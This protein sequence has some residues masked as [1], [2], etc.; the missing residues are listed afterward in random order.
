M[1]LFGGSSTTEF[2]FQKPGSPRA[3]T[4]TLR[5]GTG[6][7]GCFTRT[8][9]FLGGRETPHVTTRSNAGVGSGQR[10]PAPLEAWEVVH[11]SLPRLL[12]AGRVRQAVDALGERTAGGSDAWYGLEQ[13]HLTR[14]A[15]VLSALAHAYMFGK[16]QDKGKGEEKIG[17]YQLPRH[18]LYAWDRVP[19]D[20]VLNNAVGN[21][22]FSLRSIYFGLPEERL[23]SGLQ[24]TIESV[25]APALSDMALAKS[26]VLADQPDLVTHCLESL[27]ARI[28]E[29]AHVFDAMTPRDTTHFDPVIWIKTYPAMG[30]P[31]TPGELGNSGVD[32]PIFHAL[33]AFIG[34]QNVKGD[35]KG[36][37]SDRRATL[38]ANIRA[39]LDALGDRTGGVRDY[40]AAAHDR[41]RSLPSEQQSQ[42]QRL[43]AAW[44]GLLQM[45]V[46]FLERH[47][48]KA[49][50]VTGVSLGTGR[51][52]TSSGVK[53]SDQTKS[54]AA[55]QPKMRPETMLSMQMKMGMASRL[56]GRPLW[57][58]ARVQSQ[59]K[60]QGSVVVTV[61]LDVNL[62]LEPGDRVQIWPPMKRK[63][64]R[65]TCSHTR[66]LRISSPEE[67][68]ASP[69]CESDDEAEA[70]PRFYSIA[71]VNPDVVNEAT[72]SGRGGGMTIALTVGQ[73]TPE[74]L[75]SSFLSTAAQG[76]HLRLRPWPSLRFRQPRNMTVPLVLIG[77]GS[78]AGPLLGF[79]HDRAAWKQR[80]GDTQDDIEYR[81][82]VHQLVKSKSA[83]V[84]V[85]GSSDFGATVMS[86]LGLG[87]LQQ[88]QQQQQQQ[89]KQAQD[90]N[91]ESFDDNR[92]EILPPPAYWKQLHHDLFAKVERPSISRSSCC[93][94][95]PSISP[96][97]P[98]ISPATLAA[99]NSMT[100]C[101]T[102]IGGTVYDMTSFLATHPGGPKTI[103][104]SA[105]TVAD[106][107]FVETHGGPHAQEIRGYLKSYAIGRLSTATADS[108]T[109]MTSAKLINA[110]VRMQNALTNNSAFD[111]SRGP[112]PL[113]VY[114]DALLVFSDDLDG[115]VDILS[116]VSDE[117]S[118]SDLIE[119]VV[120][121]Q[122]LLRKAFVVLK[123]G[124][125]GC[126]VAAGS[127]G[128]SYTPST[129]LDESEDLIRKLYRGPIRKVHTAID[130][131]KKGVG[132]IEARTETGS[133]DGICDT[134][135]DENADA[136]KRVLEKFCTSLA[137]VA[138]DLL[139]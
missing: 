131:C 90:A 129:L 78:G 50:G 33:D 26:G 121:T 39:F 60:Y 71:R 55:G 138:K 47:R 99:H 117:N 16:E 85:C 10:L 59:T 130:V 12:R 80:L 31:V 118:S 110:L 17:R 34:R 15:L 135:D 102:A 27:A 42:Y 104:E 54:A 109:Q 41:Q 88:Q 100:S 32:A 86:S 113:Y 7:D 73:H 18:V 89:Q 22:S 3:V 63:K 56:A 95:S 28:I 115:I 83:H 62:P 106:A 13:R 14:A 29:C 38:P 11:E 139:Y 49:V 112:V 72:V 108:A 133:S 48:V 76:T 35:L 37:Q 61:R 137:S 5:F 2:K 69:G 23:S 1:Q 66:R 93:S 21:D 81:D 65:R 68:D 45:Y 124:C 120:N 6:L 128:S 57:Q 127:K 53:S 111:A 119:T 46:W 84:F 101:W 87:Q 8:R 64:V 79:L 94:S 116:D 107:R 25:F 30:R 82:F 67:H 126:L 98:I 122:A 58:D 51:H 91:D 97:V 132:E 123:D 24:G 92:T 9:G 4:Q 114:E 36:M 103:L 75:V 136:L 77:Q 43:S 125:K 134:Y 105:G 20:D 40:I 70:E 52:S 44:D 96:K 19:A 74:G